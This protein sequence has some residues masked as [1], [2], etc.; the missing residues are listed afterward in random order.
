[1]IGHSVRGRPIVVV[2]RS[3]PAKRGCSWSAASTA[4]S[5]PGWGH[6]RAAGQGRSRRAASCGWCRV[7][8]GRPAAD[9]RQNAHG[10]DLNRNF[11][12]GRTVTP[13][14]STTRARDPLSE[15]ET[16]AAVTTDHGGP[17]GSRSGT[18]STCGWCGHRGRASRAGRKV[19]DDGRPAAL[20]A[21]VSWRRGVAV[22]PSPLPPPARVRRR[23]SRRAALSRGGVRRHVGAVLAMAARSETFALGT[24]VSPGWPRWSAG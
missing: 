18:T 11:R 17:A 23:A 13:T 6:L 22:D 19:R 21:P 20:R 4:T 3:A 24:G 12:Y 2:G 8:S 5:P 1:M 9:T 16:R 7:E 15:P 14:R 10:V